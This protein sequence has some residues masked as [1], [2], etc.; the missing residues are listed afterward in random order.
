[1]NKARKLACFVCSL[2]E[3]H[4]RIKIN[5]KRIKNMIKIFCKFAL[6]S[7]HTHTHREENSVYLIEIIDNVF[8]FVRSQHETDVQPFNQYVEQKVKKR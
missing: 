5:E 6:F 8:L 7:T 1:M 3:A 2:L 4:L